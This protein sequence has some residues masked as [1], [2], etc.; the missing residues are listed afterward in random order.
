M[1]YDQG[2]TQPWSTT[3]DG[4]DFLTNLLDRLLS[5][6][7]ESP[8]SSKHSRNAIL[9]IIYLAVLGCC[10]LSPCFFYLRFWTWQRRRQR[11]LRELEGA[12]LA[13]AMAR[14][15]GPMAIDE[16]HNSSAVQEERKAR[17]AQLVEPVRM[18]R[19]SSCFFFTI[20]RIL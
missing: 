10:C 18:V 12:G 4:D 3:G 8:T 20:E 2:M 1:E 6:S 16:H 15:S 11:R 5:S 7:V 14:S 17:I 19:S 13:V 9:Y